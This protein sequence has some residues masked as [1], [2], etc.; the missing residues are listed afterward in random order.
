[1]TDHTSKH[2]LQQYAPIEGRSPY[3]HRRLEAWLADFCDVPNR[4]FDSTLCCGLA[5]AYR[6]CSAIYR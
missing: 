5:N 4:F 3:T 6:C 2:N 1:M